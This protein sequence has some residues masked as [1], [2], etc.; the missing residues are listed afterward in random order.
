[1]LNLSSTEALVTMLV[2]RLRQ[3]ARAVDGSGG[4]GGRD[5]FEHTAGGE[6]LVYETKSF[7]SRLDQTRRK[8]V[9]RSLESAARHQPDRWDLLVPIDHNPAELWWFEGLREQFPFVREWRGR[10]WLDEKFAAHPDL[11]RYALQES[12]DYILQRIAEA[13]AKRDVLL[14]GLT[15]YLERASALH[16]RAA[17]LA[18][19]AE[20]RLPATDRSPGR[21]AGPGQGTERQR[22]RPA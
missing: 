6:L 18:A 17:G 22:V 11:V 4:D 16:A 10:S 8:Q 19:G 2:L 3:G 20:G 12:G 14:G 21:P 15:D 9:V 5:L 13:R 7:T 1:M